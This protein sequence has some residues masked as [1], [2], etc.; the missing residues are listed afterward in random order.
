MRGSGVRLVHEAS[1][2]AR[3]QASQ[4]IQV[5]DGNGRWTLP[6]GLSARECLKQPE[7]C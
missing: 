6:Q 3:R 4:I 1:T 5:R 7:R 2:G